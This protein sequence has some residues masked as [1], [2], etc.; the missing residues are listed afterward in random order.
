ML[1]EAV[2]LRKEN[3]FDLLEVTTKAYRV[4]EGR[5]Y[6]SLRGVAECFI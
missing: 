4:M 6:K 3:L 1:G 2:D 5:I